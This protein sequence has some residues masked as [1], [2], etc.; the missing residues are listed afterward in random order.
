[1]ELQ[2]LRC[3]ASVA[4]EL[5][6]VRAAEKLHMAQQAVSYQIK[7]LEQELGV[8]LFHRTTRKVTLTMAG[9][10][11]LGEVSQVFAHLDRGV[12]EARRAERG[13]RGRLVIGY[14]HTM[15]YSVLPAS[16]KR[17]RDRHPDVKIE[18]LESTPLELEKKLLNGEVDV[19]LNVKAVGQSS[20][21]DLQCKSLSVER[22]TV[23]VSRSHPL[24]GHKE[25]KLS[26]LSN[27]SFV[28]VNGNALMQNC[29]RYVCREAGFMPRII[30]EAA[31]E[32]SAIFLAASGM[33]VALVFG[34]LNKLYENQVVYLPL[35]DPLFEFEFALFWR[36]DDTLSQVDHFIEA[37]TGQRA[38]TIAAVLEG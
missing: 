30:Q 15:S 3:F 10:A 22:M 21:Q 9:E 20:L 5:H 27:E 31:N 17:F 37:C 25:V 38:R 1:M 34:F 12:E 32:Q 16:V 33:G 29:F 26:E 8:Q 2:Q 19:A 4:S 14:V 23:A 13:E 7:Q 28:L 36:K 18:L 24:A 35:V 6:F 11:F